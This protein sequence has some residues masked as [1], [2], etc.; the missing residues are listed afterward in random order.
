MVVSDFLRSADGWT[1]AGPHA[2]QVELLH[3]PML[4]EGRDSGELSWFFS[5]PAKFLGDQSQMY[6]GA[7]ALRVGFWEHAGHFRNGSAASPEFDVVLSSGTAGLSLGRA[8]LVLPLAFVNTLQVTLR[9][10]GGWV[11]VGRAPGTAPSA[12]EFR[13]VLSS[14][15]QVQRCVVMCVCARTHTTHTHTH[16]HT[17]TAARSTLMQTSMPQVWVR[18][19][20]YSGAEEAYIMAVTMSPPAASAEAEGEGHEQ[21]SSAGRPKKKQL[22]HSKMKAA[23]ARAGVVGERQGLQELP[24]VP[25]GGCRAL[26]ALE[27]ALVREASCSTHSRRIVACPLGV[28]RPGFCALFWGEIACGRIA[29]DSTSL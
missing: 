12:E 15:S 16:T 7:L 13:R 17:H 28:G 14:L 29:Y 23:S 11:V 22:D 26:A 25:R 24:Q 9:E 18:G 19:G 3:A 21:G 5:A 8:S 20:Y 6:G 27:D 4:V 2:A 10:D 1:A